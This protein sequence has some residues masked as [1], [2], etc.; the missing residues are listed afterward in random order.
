MTAKSL[1]I[2]IILPLLI[3]AL[4]AVVFTGCSVAT[5][6]VTINGHTATWREISDAYAYEVNVNDTTFQT[7]DTSVNLIEYIQGNG[8]ATV[9]VRALS[10]SFFSSSSGY[11][12]E[13]TVSTSAPRLNAPQNF[14]IT[15]DGNVYT[16]S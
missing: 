4:A 9:R 8:S 5:P 3:I 16:L 7:S 13:I 10:N 14:N 12:D 2:K 6:E 15:V 11:S 1:S